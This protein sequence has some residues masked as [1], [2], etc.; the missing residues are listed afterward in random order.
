LSMLNTLSP[1]PFTPLLER[2]PTFYRVV[3]KGIDFA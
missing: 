1:L 2:D 3:P